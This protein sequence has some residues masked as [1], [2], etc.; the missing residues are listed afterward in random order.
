M[1]IGATIQARMGSSRLPGKVLMPIVGKPMLELQTER[2]LQSHLIDSLIIA[3]STQAQDDPI[4]QLAKRLGVFCYRG[5]EENVLNRITQALR[6]YQVDLHVEFKGDGPLV[7]PLLVD[8][9]I[10]YYLK[11]QDRIDYLTNGMKTTYP[12]GME[13]TIYPASVLWDAE[14][15]I[16]DP[17]DLEHVA[18]NIESHADRY[19][20]YNLEAPAWF[21]YPE[22]YLEVDT[23]E[24][25]E[26][27]SA[28]FENFYPEN[29]GFGLAQMIDFMKK[30]PELANR[31][32]F[33]HRRWKIFREK[34]PIPWEKV[35]R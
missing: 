17:A 2:I 5:S 7:D 27:V 19:R 20:L 29:P 18:W 23:P 31:N 12:P 24:D 22:F 32:R 25:F 26:V 4:E 15:R 10:G 3:T 21:H 1:K 33:V 28:V 16:R 13:V 30:H 14:S 11:S 8:A 6:T 35:I 9:M 34:N